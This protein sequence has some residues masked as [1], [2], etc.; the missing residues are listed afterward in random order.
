MMQRFVSSRAVLTSRIGL[1]LARFARDA[2]GSIAIEF[3]IISPLLL[4]MLLGTIE[5][6]RAVSIDRH[7]SS[8]VATVGDLVAREKFMGTNSSGAT[9]NLEKMM[10]AIQHLMK[11]YDGSKLKLAIVAVQASTTNQ[12]DTKVTWSY[13]HGL[14]AKAK[15][16]K[17]TLPNNMLVKG[18][19]VIVVEAEYGFESLFKGYFPG[20]SSKW[21]DKTYHSPRNSCVDLVEGDNCTNSC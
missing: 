11:P 16:S 14:S 17:Y 5:F 15:C 3:G 7:F 1:R 20:L 10:E 9:R 6:G 18:S 19:S 21:E 12:N 8:A 4:L 2:K 13:S